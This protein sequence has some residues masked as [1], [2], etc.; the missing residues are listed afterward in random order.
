LIIIEKETVINRT[1]RNKTNATD[2]SLS[3]PATTQ[4]TGKLLSFLSPHE[5]RT[6][7]FDY[8][9]KGNGHQSYL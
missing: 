1:C 7:Q 3:G 5:A 2:G 9:R 4:P 8:Y 6:T